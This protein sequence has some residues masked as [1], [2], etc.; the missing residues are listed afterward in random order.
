MLVFETFICWYLRHS[1]VLGTLYVCTLDI[2]TFVLS[3]FVRL[4][5]GHCYVHTLDIRASG[6]FLC[7]YFGEH[8]YICTSVLAW[9]SVHL[10]FVRHFYFCTS[11][12]ICTF[13]LW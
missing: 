12:S 8:L 13:V 6:I 5:I 10:Y 9:T 4:H 2:S 3:L 11:V 1:L 7:L